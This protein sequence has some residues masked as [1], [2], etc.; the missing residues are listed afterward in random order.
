MYIAVIDRYR[1]R[2][3]YQKWR[4]VAQKISSEI[5]LP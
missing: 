5:D 4:E 3:Y 1:K 2:K